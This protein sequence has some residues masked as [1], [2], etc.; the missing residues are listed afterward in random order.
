MN[1]A[2]N[3]TAGTE[4]TTCTVPSNLSDIQFGNTYGH[5]D[6]FQFHIKHFALFPVRLIDA[7]LET[8]TTG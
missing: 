8:I 5:S 2:F 6:F 1:E 7:D 3:G 4:D